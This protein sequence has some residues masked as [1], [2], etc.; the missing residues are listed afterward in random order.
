MIECSYLGRSLVG[1]CVFSGFEAVDA[2]L[3]SYEIQ[4]MPF[5][6]SSITCII[7]GYW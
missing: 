5:A 3:G 4:V 1:W 2:S 6:W 7:K